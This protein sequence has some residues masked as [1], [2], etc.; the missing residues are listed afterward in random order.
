MSI[1]SAG[2]DYF[3]KGGPV[4]YPLLF[5]SLA[6]I[7]ISVER[8]LFFRAKDSGRK[9]TRE[10]VIISSATIGQ[11]RNNLPILRKGNS[12]SWRLSSWRGMGISSGW[13]VSS[14]SGRSVRWINLS[15]TSII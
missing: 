9:F 8:Y 11:M 4:M 12:R 3:V 14:M 2:L 10:F 6:A 13:K 5:C 15:S 7:A 1:F